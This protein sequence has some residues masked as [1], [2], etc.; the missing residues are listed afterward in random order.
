MDRIIS[1]FI[2]RKEG[3]ARHWW[4]RLITVAIYASTFIVLINPLFPLSQLSGY[5]VTLP[6]GIGFTSTSKPSPQDILDVASQIGA[7][8]SPILLNSLPASMTPEQMTYLQSSKQPPQGPV[9]KVLKAIA[10]GVIDAIVWFILFE[11]II[12]RAIVY[13]IL[14]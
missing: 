3:L 6:N 12:Y 4:H 14:G 1:L 8:H 10:I 2:V 5:T 7:L 13:V 9:E 11:S